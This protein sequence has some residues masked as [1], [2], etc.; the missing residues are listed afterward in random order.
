[1]KNIR[2][3]NI[4]LVALS[5]FFHS[6]N[7]A[8]PTEKDIIGEWISGDGAK[9]RFKANGTFEGEMLPG[10]HF[11][12]QTQEY[13]GKKVHG[14]GKWLLKKGQGWWEISMN[15]NK[16]LNQEDEFDTQILISGSSGLLSQNPPWYLFE[17]KDEEGGERYMFKK[18]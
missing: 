4:A 1:M 18:H 11:F 7:S 2:F 15:F 5:F 16:I 6:C 3:V 13:K 12:G 10:E 8:V 9:L 14:S 17:W